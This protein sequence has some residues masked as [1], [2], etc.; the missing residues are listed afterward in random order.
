MRTQPQPTLMQASQLCRP[1]KD[2]LPYLGGEACVCRRSP[3]N[4]ALQYVKTALSHHKRLSKVLYHFSGS[5]I[6]THTL[7]FCRICLAKLQHDRTCGLQRF[8]ILHDLLNS[9]FVVVFPPQ[10]EFDYSKVPAAWFDIQL[11]NYVLHFVH[12]VNA[13]F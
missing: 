3:V 13:I 11:L 8:K 1:L 9:A 5:L 2:H 7:S 12:G 4:S 6:Y 10:R